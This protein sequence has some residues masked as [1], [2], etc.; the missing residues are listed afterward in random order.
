MNTI[1]IDTKFFAILRET[2]N[3]TDDSVF[4]P[5]NSTVNDF[6]QKLISDYGD[7]L[8]KILLNDDGLLNEQFTTLLNGQSITADSFS[9]I[10]LADN[11]L[12]IFLP[13]ISGG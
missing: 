3:K 2:I 6:L 11:D 5:S 8:S 10:R 9:N 1:R 4:L 12:L 7:V 13:P